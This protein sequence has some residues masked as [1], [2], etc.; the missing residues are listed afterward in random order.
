[1]FLCLVVSETW[2][3]VSNSL[4]S[5]LN[6]PSTIQNM[7]TQFMLWIVYGALRAVI[8]KFE[9][10]NQVSALCLVTLCAVCA[11]E[12]CD[13]SRLHIMYMY[14]YTCHKISLIWHLPNRKSPEKR[15][16]C[17]LSHVDIMNVMADCWF[18]PGLLCSYLCASLGSWG[19]GVRRVTSGVVILMCYASFHA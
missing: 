5:A 9:I 8:K 4:I 14:V 15:S 11:E 19:L 16:W 18:T 10:S 2:L 3:L 12:L 1:M 17:F 7:N 6:A 13:R